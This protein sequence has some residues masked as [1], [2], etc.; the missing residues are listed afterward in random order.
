MRVVRQFT[1]EPPSASAYFLPIG[2]TVEDVLMELHEKIA[3]KQDS[4]KAEKLSKLLPP[5][6]VRPRKY[7][8]FEG[9][10]SHWILL[11]PC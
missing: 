5:L 1:L 4:M 3:T 8:R 6:A 7:H 10:C 9:D 11:L 2:E